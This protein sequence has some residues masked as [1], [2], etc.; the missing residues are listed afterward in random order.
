[1]TFASELQRLR[2]FLDAWGHPAAVIGGVAIAARAHPRFTDDID[3]VIAVS[4]EDRDRLLQVAVAN[5]YGYDPKEA[6][7]FMEGGLLRLWGP[8]GRERGIGVDLLFSDSPFMEKVLAR[9]TVLD[10]V[11]TSLPVATV[12]DLILLKLE[13]NRP[14]DLEDVIAMKDAVGEK[15]DLRYLR[16]QAEALGIAERVRAFVGS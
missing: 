13:A 10:A 4:T 7:T 5:G 14:A 3:V 8:P 6:A 11:G 2:R 12:E 16:E 1:M 9:A 15:L